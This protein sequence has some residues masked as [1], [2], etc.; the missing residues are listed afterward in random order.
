M[1][2]L[3][4]IYISRHIFIVVYALDRVLLLYII[5]SGHTSFMNIY[6]YDIIYIRI[7]IAPHSR[8]SMIVKCK[9]QYNVIIR[10]VMYLPNYYKGIK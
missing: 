6:A 3:I 7:V 1:V 8:Y 10:T 4:V 5:L 9:D 2:M